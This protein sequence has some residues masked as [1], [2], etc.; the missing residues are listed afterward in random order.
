MCARPSWSNTWSGAA[1]AASRR[2]CDRR[3]D[4]SAHRTLGRGQVHCP[5]R[6]NR[7][8]GLVGQRQGNVG[9][10]VRTDARRLR[11]LCPAQATICPG[12]YAGAG[13]DHRLNTRI[14]TE[15]AWHALF[16]RHLL[17]RPDAAELAS[18]V[19]EF[20]VVDL[21][22]FRAAPLYHG[23]R[24]ET[25]IACNFSKRIVLIGGTSYAGE[26]KKSVFSSSIIFCRRGT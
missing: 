5:R 18:F 7:P 15:Y 23:T 17:R 22:S 10:A 19:P 16:I 1:K 25:V 26:I 11:Q 8:R 21:P 2:R 3:R 14:V 12:P 24:T 13:T 9:R 6:G 4:G 20:T